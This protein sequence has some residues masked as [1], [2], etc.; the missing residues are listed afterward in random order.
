MENIKEG[1]RAVQEKVREMQGMTRGAP[2]YAPELI[3]Q[4]TRGASKEANKNVANDS[5]VDANTR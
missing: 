3:Q 2:N 1:T 4:D 5:N